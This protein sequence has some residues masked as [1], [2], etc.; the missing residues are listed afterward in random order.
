MSTLHKAAFDAQQTVFDEKLH[1]QGVRLNNATSL[2]AVLKGE[3]A[4]YRKLDE[5]RR[6]IAFL[7]AGFAGAVCLPIGIL[8]GYYCF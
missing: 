2:I 6:L 8:I 3:N 1:K 4:A 5:K 7:F